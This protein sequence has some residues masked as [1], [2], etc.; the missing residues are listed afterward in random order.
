VFASRT[1][2]RVCFALFAAGG[3]AHAEGGQKCI[4]D[5][6]SAQSQRQAGHY[7]A[8]LAKFQSCAVSSCP[9]AINQECSGWVAKVDAQFPSVVVRVTD[10]T[11]NTRKTIIGA[12]VSIDGFERSQ[13]SD[14]AGIKLDPGDHVVRAEA[15]GYVPVES[16]FTLP[17]EHTKVVVSLVMSPSTSSA[18]PAPPAALPAPAPPATSTSKSGEVASVDQGGGSSTVFMWVFGGVGVAGM[19]GFT[20]LGLSGMH[21]RNQLDSCKPQCDPARVDQARLKLTLAD[22]SLG[23][24]VASLGAAVWLFFANRN[25]SSGARAHVGLSALPGG[26][27]ATA[28]TRF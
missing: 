14:S 21:D 4:A 6:E 11:Q 2:T 16:H 10:Q 15:G 13:W 28:G 27:S 20:Y 12:R 18:E 22:V 19:A 26:V 1:A 7:A 25:D 9:S 23:V 3:S 17:A 24:G 8:A 5:Y